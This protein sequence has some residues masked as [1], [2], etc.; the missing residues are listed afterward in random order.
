[1]RNYLTNRMMYLLFYKPENVCLTSEILIFT[2]KVYC[3]VKYCACIVN[4]KFL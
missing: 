4:S 2:L 1:M 3:G